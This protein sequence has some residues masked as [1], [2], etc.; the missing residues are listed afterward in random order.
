MTDTHQSSREIL[1][2]ISLGNEA[3]SSTETHNIEEPSKEL[4]TAQSPNAESPTNHIQEKPEKLPPIKLKAFTKEWFWEIRSS[5]FMIVLTISLSIFTDVFVYS[6]VVPVIPFAF[7]TRMGVPANDVQSEVDKALAIYSVGLVIGSVIFGWVA[8]KI[9]QRQLIM[10]IGLV[11]V[12]G[13]TIIL[14]VAKV[15]WLY[16]LGRFIQGFSAAIVWTAGLAIIADTGEAKDMSFLM[17]FPGIATSLGV[18]LGPFLGGVLYEKAGYYAVF[19]VCIGILVLDLILRLFM[20]ERNQLSKFRHERAVELNN[21]DQSTLSASSILYMDRYLAADVFTN[22]YHIAKQR[23]LQELYGK[24]V[25]LFGKR[26]RIPDLIALMAYPRVVNGA[27]LGMGLAWIASALDATLPLHMKSIFGFNSLQSSLV[28]LAL[29]VPTVVEPLFGLL[30][31]R[32]G[33]KY[34]ISGC[35]LLLGPVLICLRIPVDREL[36]D[37][38]T[39]VA[40]V[41][42]VGLFA[43]GAASPSLAE[44]TLAL[45]E[46]EG[47]HPG[48]YGKG[49]GFGKAYGLFNVGYAVG[50]IIGPVQAGGVLSSKG[51]GTASL[52]LGIVCFIVAIVSFFFAGGKM[53]KSETG[54]ELEE[55]RA[56]EL[57]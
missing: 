22:E 16:S 28:F 53:D 42:L 23:E 38:L 49:K 45:T 9:K 15:L 46:I 36:H 39:F 54:K 52:S 13:A 44:M 2:P 48:I 47:R 21:A 27:F 14:C 41:A 32:F 12:L 7:E 55:K 4:P 19:Y 11:V 24:Y 34:V 1:V 6:I 37:K 3:L 10:I 51:W 57:S 43:I 5:T 18:F 56:E 29:A 25:T 33:P 50:A 17:S 40:L 30:S 26:F 35:Y 20:L 8:D 31:D